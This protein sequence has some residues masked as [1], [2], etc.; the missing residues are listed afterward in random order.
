MLAAK[1]SYILRKSITF[2]LFQ[3]LNSVLFERERGRFTGRRTCRNSFWQKS[4]LEKTLRVTCSKKPLDWIDWNFTL[5][6]QLCTLCKGWSSSF[7]NSYN[8]SSDILPLID[9]FKRDCVS[10]LLLTTHPLFTLAVFNARNWFYSYS[11]LL[12]PLVPFRCQEVCR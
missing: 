9:F 4:N 6:G 5:N 10:F 12:V 2:N 11:L 3:W 8:N 1:Y 7:L